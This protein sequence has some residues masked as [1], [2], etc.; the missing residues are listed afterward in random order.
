M[1]AFTKPGSSSVAALVWMSN[2]CNRIQPPA[3]LFHYIT[4]VPRKTSVIGYSSINYSKSFY[5]IEI[6]HFFGCGFRGL[7]RWWEK[8][9]LSRLID[10]VEQTCKCKCK[11][12]SI[13]Q[14]SRVDCF[15]FQIMLFLLLHTIGTT[16]VIWNPYCK[17]PP[18]FSI[19]KWGHF[20]V[21]SVWSSNY[22]RLIYSITFRLTLCYTVWT[23]GFLLTATEK[24]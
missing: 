15:L 23:R 5:H 14:T 2:W 16:V 17:R 20:S 11:F 21:E 9:R 13:T 7:K 3:Q 8:I 24:L 6:I 22:L 1:P 19:K 12:V 18:C 10:N 4:V